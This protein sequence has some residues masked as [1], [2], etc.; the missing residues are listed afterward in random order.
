MF[1]L[2]INEQDGV[3][4][5]ELITFKASDTAL[6]FLIANEEENQFVICD[7][8]SLKFY[9][10]NDIQVCSPSHLKFI[11]NRISSLFYL[12]NAIMAQ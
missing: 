10:C 7:G 9:E 11:F 5:D 2:L 12:L 4:A 8:R 1:L 3:S 6:N